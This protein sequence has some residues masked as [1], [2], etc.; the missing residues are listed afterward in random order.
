M[1]KEQIQGFPVSVA[2]LSVPLEDAVPS[3]FHESRDGG[4]V[5][6]VHC[7]QRRLTAL[8]PCV[9]LRSP[10]LFAGRAGVGEGTRAITA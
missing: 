6:H 8:V 10:E 4:R 2:P 1:S 9:S 3:P 5:L 7:A